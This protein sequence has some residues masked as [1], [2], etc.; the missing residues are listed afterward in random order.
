MP[1]HIL[2]T[3]F[4]KDYSDDACKRIALVYILVLARIRFSSSRIVVISDPEITIETVNVR[5]VLQLQLVRRRQ[6]PVKS[7]RQPGIDPPPSP[8]FSIRTE[9]QLTKC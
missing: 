8:P 6:Q 4:W 3:V 7:G 9:Q 5:A 2:T 1:L